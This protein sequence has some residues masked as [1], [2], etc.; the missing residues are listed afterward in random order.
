MAERPKPT[1][2]GADKSKIKI[3]FAK[4]RKNRQPSPTSVAG[5]GRTSDRERDAHKKVWTRTVNQSGSWFLAIVIAAFLSNTAGFHHLPIYH[6]GESFDG[7]KAFRQL[8]ID[9]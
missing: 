6:D 1:N 4:P 7:N 3:R 9:V 2:P 5:P 8:C